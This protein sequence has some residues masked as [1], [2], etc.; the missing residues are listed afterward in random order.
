MRNVLHGGHGFVTPSQVENR[1]SDSLSR[2]YFNFPRAPDW[3]ESMILGDHTGYVAHAVVQHGDSLQVARLSVWR[4][5]CRDNRKKGQCWWIWEQEA[6]IVFCTFWPFVQQILLGVQDFGQTPNFKS[7]WNRMILETN[8]PLDWDRKLFGIWNCPSSTDT[9]NLSQSV[10]KGK[11]IS[12]TFCASVTSLKVRGCISWAG[13]GCIQRWSGHC[14]MALSFASA[15][16]V[17]EWQHI[18]VAPEIPQVSPNAS[19]QLHPPIFRSI[20]HYHFISLAADVEHF[21]VA[22]FLWIWK[23]KN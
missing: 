6:L 20:H 5:N 14:E 7:N 16:S 17:H 3:S 2:F 21:H 12:F 18:H 13:L 1:Q 19:P 10:V 4:R 22:V 11:D 15:C 8:G 9:S 23:E